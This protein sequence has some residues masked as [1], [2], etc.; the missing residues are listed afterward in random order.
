M[1][2]VLG[3]TPISAVLGS[4][5]DNTNHE[6]VRSF[7]RAACA[8]GL[9]LLLIQPGLKLPADMRTPHKRR[10]DD[11]EAQATAQAAGRA[12]W[13]R[14]KSPSGLALA[15]SDAKVVLKYL[16]RYIEV[17]GEDVAV[18]LAIEVGGSGLVVVDCDT[19]EQV[20]SFL[21]EAEAPLDMPPTV[22]TPG[23]TDAEGNWVHSD[24]GHF[25]F[26]VPDG[27][28]LPE[29]VG[30]MSWG[31]DNG[32]AVLW[33]RRYVLIPPSTRAEGAYELVG[34]DYPLPAWLA[35]KIDEHGSARAAR[36][37]ERD[38][39]VD[40]D[41]KGGIDA[42]AD[43]ITWDEILEPQGWTPTARPDNC[44]C[45]VWTAP[46]QHASPK[47]ATAH[48]AG[49]GRAF[50]GTNSPLHIW[51]DHDVAPFDDF[52]ATHGT[53][54]TKL[55][56]VAVTEYDGNVGKALD[57]LKLAPELGIG[58]EEGLTEA[59]LADDELSD[60]PGIDDD[61]TPDP[62]PVDSPVDDEPAADPVATMEVDEDMGFGAE[63]ES[64]PF[65]DEV[66]ADPNV[67]ESGINGVPQIAPFAHWKDL[68]APEYVIDGLIEHLGFSCL[69]GPPGVGKSAIALDMACHIA[70]GK[71]WQGRRTLKTKV[72][73]LPG[74]GLSGVVQRIAAWEHAHDTEVGDDL[75]LG[76]DIIQLKASKE[77][78][79][80]MTE[81]LIRQ[82]IGL[83][84]F[85]TYARMSSGME[86]NS[87]TDAGLGILRLDKVRKATNAGVML[88]HHT[89]KN[90]DAGRGSSA[91]NG[92][93]DSELLV[94]DGWSR[95]IESDEDD[96]PT[97]KRIE[98][99]TT[100]QK[101]APQLDEG[102]ALLMRD[103]ESNNAPVITGPN[104]SVDPMEG[105]V[106]LARPVP[107]PVVETAI[108]IRTFVDRL[109]QQGATR[110]EIAAG[111]RPDAYTRSRPDAAKRWK[112]K[113][114]EAVDRGLRYQLIE[115]LTGTASGQR[116]IPSVGTIADARSRAASEQIG[117]DG[118]DD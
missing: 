93:L 48:D 34:R 21:T 61:F 68:P 29:H 30:A 57:D 36:A 98:L 16:D 26:T 49:C 6:A 67:F 100:K 90:S 79:S 4:G 50:T 25:Y 3:S 116:Y 105:T 83:I 104:G 75:L 39:E 9:S 22:T 46:G 88:V 97:G 81:Y 96:I 110:G 84:I 10:K 109:P 94:R 64:T 82:E 91:L 23:A 12:D 77:A 89:A 54:I 103:S 70:T 45:P 111:V 37:S 8:Q 107:E 28:I 17:F 115:T 59:N 74:E 42:W 69:I 33:N 1:I 102:L 66:E 53:T 114:A 85:D 13:Q 15:S 60:T 14:V 78:W 80:A 112:Q 18:N 113:V 11:K 7:I 20:H 106:I 99:W 117:D 101:N 65:P 27:V 71:T 73:Y 35:E 44:G 47:S 31:G 51:T 19:A 118:D 24:G 38:R 62:Q 32:F 52:V 87:A 55:Q 72:L 43:T 40:E 41:L 86:E 108:R 92:A 76:N 5:V 58:A 56:A 2:P 63:L 95:E